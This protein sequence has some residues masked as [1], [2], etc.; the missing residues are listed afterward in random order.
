MKDKV[1]R[2]DEA[3]SFLR[4]GMTVMMGGFMGVGAPEGLVRAIL[5]SGLN[6][7]TLISSDTGTADKGCGPLVVQRRVK[8]LVASH[9]GTNPETGRQMIAGELEVELTP[10]GTFAERIRAGG[11]GLGGVLTRTGLGTLVEEGKP[12]V[13]VDGREYLLETPLRADVALLKAY[14]AD[15]A[16]NLVFRKSARNFNPIMA[17]A[18]DLVIAEAEQIVEIG[19]LDPDSIVTPGILVDKIVQ[20]G[21]E[22]E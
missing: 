14:K 6:Q 2:L 20:S 7:L 13:A 16:G 19:E 18:A 12:K 5:D 11:A 8:K 9:I 15:R 10:Q 1:I 17:L 3:L 22:R 21:G 4:S